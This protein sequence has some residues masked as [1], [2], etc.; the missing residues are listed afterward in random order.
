MI[1]TLGRNSKILAEAAT[2]P[3]M[4][5]IATLERDI[6]TV[7]KSDSK[8]RN[9]IFLV[10]AEQENECYSIAVNNNQIEIKAADD[11]GFI[12]GIYHISR[13]FL[14]IHDLWFWNNQKVD[15]KECV[16]IPDAYSYQMTPYAVKQRGWFVNDEVLL[17][18]WT[19]EGDKDKPWEMV[20]EALLRLGG[21]MVVPGTDRNAI[22]YR[23]L[24]AVMG[25]KVT[26]H[27]AEPLGA[28]MFL[29][30]YPDLNPSYD[31]HPE[32]F[33]QLWI[34]GIERQKDCQVIW[35]LGFR[36]QGDCPFWAND[37]RYQTDQ[38]RGKL[39]SELIQI[40]YNLVKERI[41][42]AVCCTNIYGETME[43]YQG[44][45]LSIP[46]G[47]IKIWA[48]NGYGKMVTRRLEK[49]YNP[50]IPSLPEKED[51]GSH[52]IY[53]HVSYYDL[54]AGSHITMLPNEPSF[55]RQE[56]QKVL[57]VGV[58]DY[59]LINCS[60]VKP[61]VYYLDFIATMWRT[62]DI[63]IEKH[64]TGYIRKYYS[65]DNIEEISKCFVDYFKSATAFGP[66]EDEHA[67][68]QF[69]NHNVRGLISTFMKN[70]YQ[71]SEQ[72][73]WLQPKE[74]FEEQVKLF[75]LFYVKAVE[76]YKCFLEECKKTAEILSPEASELFQDSL[77][78]QAQIYYYC[79]S[80]AQFITKS[81]QLALDKDYKNAFYY[82]GR[83]REEYVLA[84]TLMRQREHDKWKDFYENECL[85]DMKWTAN[86]IHGYMSFLYIVGDEPYFYE[87]QRQFLYSEEDR[88]VVL[89]TNM[90]NHIT[91]DELY[92][93]MKSRRAE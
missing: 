79:N 8:K 69:A 41:P 62:G 35:N 42:D 18:T 23:K 15:K 53:Y 75:D 9:D 43:L 26:H 13:C 93:L 77:L 72:L 6:E 46:E 37:P 29:R 49:N 85:T 84:N 91:T 28:E 90:E 64:R 61:H 83:A 17:H 78:L 54:L 2:R 34:D 45:H 36:G 12:Y 86:V 67:G 57:H 48:D 52:G 71:P 66:N 65:E 39:I 60:N 40:Q 82:A 4:R 30:A 27:H 24:A 31:E 14:G 21:N 44:G 74:T 38:E 68:E 63:D 22:R 16:V 51:A 20:F 88:R 10:K 5:A 81:L 73:Q 1:I 59:W 32:K 92:A 25:L 55:I 7:F 56:L 70:S 3:V 47:V 80:G 19:L 89:I 50:R 87:W 33:Q 11:L 76:K 58:K